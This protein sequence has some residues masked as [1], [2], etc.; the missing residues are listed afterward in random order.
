[1]ATLR[2]EIVRQYVASLKEDSELDYIFPILLERMGYRIL[3]T[4]K[5]SKGQSQYGRDVVAVKKDKG[6][7]TLYLIELKGFRAHDVNDRTLNEKDGLIESMRASKNTPYRDASI[8]GLDTYARKYVY[9]H[10]GTVDANSVPTLDGFVANEF[11]NGEFERWDLG[12]LTQM[13]S[14]YL[15]EETLLTD[16]ESYKLFKRLLVL[17]DSEGND[18]SDIVKLVDLQ[19]ARMEGVQKPT[20]RAV[21]NFFATLR[22]IGAMVHYY[23]EQADNLYP[24]KYCMDTIILKTWGWILRNK[25]EGKKKIIMLFHPLVIQQLDIYEAYLNRIIAATGIENG[26]YGFDSRGPEQILY[27]LRCYDFLNDILYF[28]FS[29]ETVYCVSKN[30][31]A[32]RKDILKEIIRNNSGFKMPLLDTHSIPIQLLFLYFMHRPADDDKSF[33]A[34]YLVECVINMIRRHSTM[35]LWP[36]MLG[37]RMALAKSMYEK[38]DDYGTSSSLLITTILELLS[39]MG[40]DDTYV[41]L[42]KQADDSEVSLQIAY[43]IQDEYDIET[44]L[45]SSRLYEELSVQ[46]NLELPDS[47]SEFREKFRKPYNSISYRTDKVGYFYLRILAHIY[48]QTD[49]FPDALG[50]AFCSEI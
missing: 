8:S 40:L 5:Q 2:Q 9:V 27:P 25:L 47:V 29:S 31:I 39:Y 28:F 1:M 35:K 11:P 3:S 48:Y 4:P 45:F 21:L 38:S 32:Q 13:F 10:N 24:A 16:E 49:L 37:N 22:L 15:F 7:P 12:K 23:A 46:T 33:M 14:K 41:S 6:V 30:N 26:F 50:R 18:Y 42:K 19:L 44:A 17:L 43:P 36:E 34:D 20:D